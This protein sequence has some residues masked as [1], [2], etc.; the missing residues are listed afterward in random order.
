MLRLAIELTDLYE[1]YHDSAVAYDSLFSGKFNETENYNYDD[2]SLFFQDITFSFSDYEREIL[3]HAFQFKEEF[4]INNL[5]ANKLLGKLIQIDPAIYAGSVERERLEVASDESW[6]YATDYTM[7]YN[8]LQF[9]DSSWKR[10]GIVPTAYNQFIELGADPKS[11][12]ISKG[13]A[14]PDTGLVDSLQM[15]MSDS[16]MTIGFDTLA[17]Q[18]PVSPLLEHDSSAISETFV[19]TV[20]FRKI[21]NLEGTLVDGNIYMTADNDYILFINEEYIIDDEADNFAVV[22]TIDFGYMSYYLKSGE[23][24]LAI[25]AVDSDQSGGG[26]KIF[27]YFEMLPMDL[28]AAVEERSKV[29]KL[30][31][32]PILL[33]KL[34]T[35]NKN[36]ISINQ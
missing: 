15:G 27:G 31:I 21:I 6:L 22:D 32:D 30:D 17:A 2:A 7:G 11:M 8:R 29:E 28:T 12:W 35:L 23:N 1:A 20:Y 33:K 10:T 9:D 34:N 3:D 26:V 19:D 5:W 24:V 13:T 18:E 25:R 14:L 36:R 4:A 16:T